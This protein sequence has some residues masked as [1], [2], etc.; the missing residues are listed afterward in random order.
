MRSKYSLLTQ[1]AG[2]I[3]FPRTFTLAAGL[4]LL[5][6]TIGVA[7]APPEGPAT[8]L[9]P[10]A[11]LPLKLFLGRVPVAQVTIGGSRPLA[12][13]LDTGANDDIVNARIAR[14]L[15]LH[16]LNPKAIEQP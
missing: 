6:A 12:V 4:L 10:V 14:E 2:N 7:Q 8:A 16:V 13:I 1:L 9:R 11:E 5:T 15:G 3:T